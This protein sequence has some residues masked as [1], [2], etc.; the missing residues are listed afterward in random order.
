MFVARSVVTPVISIG[1]CLIYFDQRVR[2][3]AFDLEVLLG[4]EQAAALPTTP[5]FAPL[6][7]TATAE[8]EPNVPLP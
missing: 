7:F 2:R 3:E 1:L 8:A 4:P 6:D 5:D